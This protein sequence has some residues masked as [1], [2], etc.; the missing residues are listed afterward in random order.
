LQLP[1]TD[2]D[3]CVNQSSRPCRLLCTAPRT[4]KNP[5]RR[6]FVLHPSADHEAEDNP[7]LTNHTPY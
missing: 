1:E 7:V 6:A 5:H 3:R 4:A 2:S